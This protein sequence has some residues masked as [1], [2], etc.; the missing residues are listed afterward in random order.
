[1]S[2]A[3]SSARFQR[4]KKR[5]QLMHRIMRWYEC[6]V[7]RQTNMAIRIALQK[8]GTRE[9][10]ST[11]LRIRSCFL[12]RS[13]NL[14]SQETSQH[15]SSA[16]PAHHDWC[17]TFRRAKLSGT[18]NFWAWRRMNAAHRR[19][20]MRRTRKRHSSTHCLPF[21]MPSSAVWFKS[22]TCKDWMS[23]SSHV[24]ARALTEVAWHFLNM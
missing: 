6:V 23:W 18:H 4:A 24:S 19:Q 11:F 16:S 14:E 5:N 2:L 15:R 13:S 1:M 9:C 10:V 20:E 22:A 17:A 7:A 21:Q 12:K 3:V 8:A